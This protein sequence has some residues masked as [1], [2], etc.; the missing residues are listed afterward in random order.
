MIR[1]LQRMK[2][3]KGFTIIEL[4]V[5]IAI[6]GVL[7]AV[8]LPQLSSERSRINEANSAARDF[9]AAIQ[10]T[11]SKY[12]TY[13]GQLSNAYHNDNNLGI[14]RY[15]PLMGG[16]YPFDKSYPAA[17]TDNSNPAIASLYIMVHAE[18]DKILDVGAVTRAAAN[19]SA[20]PGMFELLKRNAADRNTE[21]SKLL[22]GEI[23]DRVS[24]NDGFYYARVDFNYKTSVT[25]TPEDIKLNTVKVAYTA[26]SRRELP[27]ASGSYAGF[28]N[29]TLTFGSDNKLNTGNICGTCSAWNETTNTRIGMKGTALI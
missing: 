3:K 8:I 11:M 27:K 17:N 10:T 9:Y 26:F 12:S 1:Y 20:D 6:M 13:D 7:M 23:D 24:F 14:V 19:T 28:V 29:S 21:F 15:Y 18:N 16:N 4:I 22:I 25:G 2:A 5:V